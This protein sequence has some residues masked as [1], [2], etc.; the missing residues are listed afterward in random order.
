MMVL[1]KYPLIEY[2]DNV[3]FGKSMIS[4]DQKLTAT[5]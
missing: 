5:K 4:K 2:I 1:L 3:R